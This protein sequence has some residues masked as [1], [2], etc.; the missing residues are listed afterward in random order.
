MQVHTA[1]G[2]RADATLQRTTARWPGCDLGGVAPRTDNNAAPAKRYALSAGALP[3]GTRNRANSRVG[4]ALEVADSMPQPN[5]ATHVANLQGACRPV[6]AHGTQVYLGCPAQ[7]LAR[8]PRPPSSSS[9]L[10]SGWV[11]AEEVATPVLLVTNHVVGDCRLR[12]SDK[13]AACGLI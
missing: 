4:H 6:G 5:A 10:G 2:G 11:G 9:A 1:P 3:A 7:R 8:T 13:T 12:W